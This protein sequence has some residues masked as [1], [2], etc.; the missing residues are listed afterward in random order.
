[1]N[2]HSLSIVFNCVHTRIEPAI[3][4]QLWAYKCGGPVCNLEK[5]TPE[6]INKFQVTMVLRFQREGMLCEPNF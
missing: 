2:I 3:L 5:T 1:M 4:K 6:Q